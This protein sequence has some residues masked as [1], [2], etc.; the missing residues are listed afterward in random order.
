MTHNDAERWRSAIGP[1]TRV[2][3]PREMREH[4]RNLAEPDFT[5]ALSHEAPERDPEVQAALAPTFQEPAEVAGHPPTARAAGNGQPAPQDLPAPAAGPTPL[6][7]GSVAIFATP[8]G[9]AV[10]CFRARGAAEDKKMVLPPFLIDMACA[11]AGRT[12]EEL[13]SA[14]REGL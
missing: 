1:G 7:E 8:D 10:I 11:Q 14:L 2:P 3:T 6:V 4:A 12:R 13:F 9:S 5:T